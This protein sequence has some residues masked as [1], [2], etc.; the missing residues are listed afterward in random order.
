M[1]LVNFE[2]EKSWFEARQENYKYLR[3]KEFVTNS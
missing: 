1:E 2:E 3:C